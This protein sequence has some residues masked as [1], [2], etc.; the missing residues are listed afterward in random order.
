MK[1][2]HEFLNRKSVD[3][4]IVDIEGNQKLQIINSRKYEAVKVLNY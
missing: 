2:F 4:F 1:L 3:D